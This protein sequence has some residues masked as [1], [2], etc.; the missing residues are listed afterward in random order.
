MK[1]KVCIVTGS[2]TGIGKETARELARQ[3]AHVV[4]ACRTKAKA[5]AAMA[6]IRGDVGDCTLSFHQLDLG[7]LAKVKESAE[8]YLATGQAIDVLVNNAGLA[9]QRG[10]TVDG[11][12]THF[13]VNHLGP[14][15]WTSLLLDRIKESAPA[16][17]VNVASKAHYDAKKLDWDCL[18]AKTKSAIS[19]REYSVSKL[20]NVLFSKKLAEYLEGTGVTTYS[21]HPGVIASDIWRK[22]PN[23]FRWLITR[24]MKDNAQGAVASLRCATDPALANESGRYYDDDGSEKKPSKLARDADL[25]EK[26][27]AFSEKAVAAYL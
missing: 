4:M 11:W 6:E 15:L 22:I 5:E 10:V 25:A 14:F 16:R 27:W 17:I 9:G 19:L 23:P 18:Q 12:E 24:K 2:N 20:A 13:G 26:L 7:S 8:A 1:G 3:G 21:L